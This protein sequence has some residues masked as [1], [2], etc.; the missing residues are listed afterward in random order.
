MAFLLTFQHIAFYASIFKQALNNT[1]IILYNL[2]ESFIT[3]V[4]IFE[5]GEKAGQPLVR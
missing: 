4:L 2:I 5:T 1:A 3:F